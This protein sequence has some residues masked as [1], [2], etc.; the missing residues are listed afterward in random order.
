MSRVAKYVLVLGLFA[1]VSSATGFGASLKAGAAEV[2]IT[3]QTGLKMYGYASRKSGA[4]GVLDPLYARTLV[5]ETGDKRFALV[6]LELGRVFAPSW[7]EQLR[8]QVKQSSGID[9][10]LVA[11][12]HTHSG[13]DPTDQFPPLNEP[14]WETPILDKVAHAI[15]EAHQ[16]AVEAR[17]GTGYGVA[18]IGH[19]RLRDNPDGTASWFERNPTMVPTAPVDPTVAILRVDNRQGEPIAILVNYACHPVIF[20]PDNLQYSADWPGVMIK[21]VKQAFAGKP[22][23]MFLQGGDGDINPYYAVTPLEQ[24]AIGRR[25]WSGEQVGR[26]AARVAKGITTQADADATLQYA[27]D[28]LPAKLR[29]DPVKF[30]QAVL[31]SWGPDAA[32]A[33]DRRQKQPMLLPVTTL[34]INKRIALATLPGE[35]F[36]EFQMDWRNRCPVED[37]FFMGYSNADF[38]YFPT[39]RAATYGGYGAANTATHVEL[40]AANRMVNQA[41]IRVYEFLGRLTDTPEDLKKSA[42]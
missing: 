17:L 6:V 10:V 28:E 42:K 13:P 7:I 34:L 29:W 25:D 37:A 21:T 2:D 36:V 26:E 41:L 16:N 19:N 14:D 39:I 40:G 12:I 4:T 27:E 35:P 11:A 33:F 23:V 30:R 24:D 20:G 1:V 38:G 8:A 18:Y 3:P 31:E 9:Y 22:V 5:L 32:A 15:D